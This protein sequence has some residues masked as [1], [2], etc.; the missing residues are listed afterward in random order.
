MKTKTVLL[1]LL[2]MASI[3]TYAQPNKKIELPPVLHSNTTTVEIRNVILSE[4][5]TVLDI[6]AFFN[7]GWWIKITSESYLLADGKKYMINEGKGIELDSLFWM[8]ASGEATFSLTFEPLPINTTTFDFMEG[9]CSDCFKI[10][11]V[12][13]V[14]DH[15]V[16]SDIPEEYSRTKRENENIVAEW[17]KGK[18]KI[19]G[20]L[21]GYTPQIDLNPKITYF[22]PVTSKGYSVP[23]ELNDDG[24][25]SKEIEIFNP[26]QVELTYDAPQSDFFRFVVAPDEETKIL[27]NLPEANRLRTK[28]KKDAP[29]YGKK[30]YFSGYAAKLNEE[31]YDESI[32]DAL[33]SRDGQ[34]EF[35]DDIQGM[36]FPEYSNYL[37]KEYNQAVAHNNKQNVSPIVKEIANMQLAL[38]MN[39]YFIF[40]ENYLTQAYIEAN[41]VS[42]EEASKLIGQLNKNETFNNYLVELPY[43]NFDKNILLTRSLD[44]KLTILGY[45][46]NPND[47]G[48]RGYIKFLMNSEKVKQEDKSIL[49]DFIKDKEDKVIVPDD[50]IAAI[51]SSYKDLQNEYLNSNVGVN[52]LSKLW[53]TEDCFLFDLLKANKISKKMID[54]NPLTKEQKEEIEEWD[55]IMQDI[56]LKENESLLAKIEENKKKTG[57][58]ILET[59][60]VADEDLFNEII[61]PFK[62]KVV[63]VDIWATWCGPCRGANIAMEP[64]KAQFKDHDLVYLYL[65]GEDSPLPT[66]ENMIPDL[67]GYHHRIADSSWNYLRDTLKASGVPTYIIIDKEGN[68]TYHSTG[69]PG[70]DT[71][72]KELLMQL[73][74]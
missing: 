32:Y 42:W 57:Y 26:S 21:I 6:D 27:I 19:S 17:K 37:L 35:I 64:L 45:A 48:A 28:I 56:I 44:E 50:S 73:N 49:A 4:D 62:D 70:V 1:V 20:R 58:T 41:K 40:A 11:G 23:V 71:I 66:W 53:N 65:A 2:F 47:G 25:F 61:K 43:I 46:T 10:W 67:K 68:Q 22:N 33:F 16:A 59:P 13:L 63:L 3:A 31:L 18:A 15:F 5:A 72:K 54:Y 29:S 74:K 39:R 30:M 8:P 69:F 12:D 60:S 38:E 34:K 9:D 24:S 51:M 55:P 36:T 7:P 14:N 52:Y